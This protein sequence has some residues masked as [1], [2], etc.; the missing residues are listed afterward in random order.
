MK[1]IK[2]RLLKRSVIIFACLMAVFG[3]SLISISFKRSYMAEQSHVFNALSACASGIQSAYAAF[4]LRGADADLSTLNEIARQYDLSAKI[5]ETDFEK[6]AVSYV[7]EGT[8]HAET[9]LHLGNALYRLSVSNPLSDIYQM[10]SI[11][12]YIYKAAYLIFLPLTAIIM[13]IS[14]RTISKPIETL[15]HTARLHT[16]GNRD[17]R[18]KINTNDEIETLSNAFNQMA[19]QVES[20]IRRRE[21]LIGDLTH[22]MKTPLQAI[23][24]ETDLMLLGK[25]TDE[26]KFGS[27]ETIHHQAQRLDRLSKRMMEWINLKD[28]ES[29]RITAC[30]LNRILENTQNLFS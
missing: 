27:L 15:T 5:S 3:S 2:F 30:A 4:V 17:A 16:G 12:T 29:A 28:N 19:D 21:E 22:E 9:D 20:E 26:E 23:I 8:L 1:K 6:S 18:A 7:R 13:Y 14:G 24:G 10:R 25:R 11:M